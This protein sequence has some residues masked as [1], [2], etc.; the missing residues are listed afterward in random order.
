ME[1]QMPVQEFRDTYAKA[2]IFERQVPT[3]DGKFF[4]SHSV[5]FQISYMDKEGKW[6]RNTI[7]IIKKNL[8]ASIRVLQDAAQC[9]MKVK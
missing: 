5:A 1:K 8:L 7:N 4:T 9:I 2:A 3:K 6:Q